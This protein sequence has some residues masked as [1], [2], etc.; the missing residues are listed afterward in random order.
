MTHRLV[1]RRLLKTVSERVVPSCTPQEPDYRGYANSTG[2]SSER[3]ESNAFSVSADEVRRC[4]RD[5]QPR[6][7]NDLLTRRLGAGWADD[8]GLALARPVAKAAAPELGWSE[9]RIEDE[10][11]AYRRH[12]ETARRRPGGK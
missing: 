6:C 11:R 2:D 8:Q 12:L 10:V 5:E 3:I 7:L 9:A 1:A 4:A